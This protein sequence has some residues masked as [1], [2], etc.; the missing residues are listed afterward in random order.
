MRQHVLCTCYNTEKQETEVTLE[1]E[2]ESDDTSEN[3]F[4]NN[5]FM[6]S[7][8]ETSDIEEE[9]QIAA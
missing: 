8:L 1:T 4:S 3:M 5:P 2:A 7:A 9:E 6:T